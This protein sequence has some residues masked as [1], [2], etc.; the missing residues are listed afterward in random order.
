[1]PALT[2]KK[3]R[4]KCSSTT[5]GEPKTMHTI[6]G[7]SKRKAAPP[8]G[9]VPQEQAPRLALS[10]TPHTAVTVV[11]I[12]PDLWEVFTI[13]AASQGMTG[14]ELVERLV[15]A[16]LAEIVRSIAGTKPPLREQIAALDEDIEA[17]RRGFTVYG[18]RGGQ[19]L[20]ASA[21]RHIA[22]LMAARNV[23]A[24]FIRPPAKGGD[25]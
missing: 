9:Q 6:K 14:D 19:R 22:C 10:K 4:R 18:P 3:S 5:D 11:D 8:K 17:T 20:P 7:R 25:R 12:D 23:L 2:L 24:A 15:A 16:D 13:H 21:R 1:M